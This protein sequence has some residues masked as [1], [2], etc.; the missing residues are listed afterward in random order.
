MAL[1]QDGV[2]FV[3]CPKQSCKIEDVVLN[4]VCFQEF[5]VLNRLRVS[6]PER[7][8]IGR[9]KPPP[10]RFKEQRNCTVHLTLSRNLA[11]IS[12]SFSSVV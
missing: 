3:L 12:G 5:Y 1:K 11:F 6:N 10:P 8:N 2:H 9:A 4:R 7:P